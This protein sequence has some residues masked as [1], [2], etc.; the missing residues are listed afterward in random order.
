[1]SEH[2][3]PDPTDRHGY[4]VIC[5]ERVRFQDID[6]YGHINNVAYGVYAETARIEWLET[7]A[8]GSCDGRGEGWL[9]VRFAVD[10][11]AQGDGPGHIDVG[12]RVLRIGTKSVTLG[13]GM[14]QGDRCL[15]TAEAVIVWADPAAEKALPLPD[16]MRPVLETYC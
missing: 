13:H 4:P 1:M 6:R 11:R 5:R 9:I 12:T 10:Y 3:A 7:L 16:A 2:P 15:A 14:F 8:P